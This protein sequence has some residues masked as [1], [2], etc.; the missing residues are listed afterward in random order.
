MIDEEGK[1]KHTHKR[2]MTTE[3]EDRHTNTHTETHVPTLKRHRGC[4]AAHAEPAVLLPAGV[5]R[6]GASVCA[7]RYPAVTHS[8]GC[9]GAKVGGQEE[10]GEVKGRIH[11]HD[12][13]STGRH[14]RK[15]NRIF[16]VAADVFSA[17]V[18]SAVKAGG[19]QPGKHQRRTQSGCG[20]CGYTRLWAEKTRIERETERSAPRQGRYS[21]DGKP[22]QQSQ[23]RTNTHTHTDNFTDRRLQ[24][25]EGRRGEEE[26]RRTTGREGGKRWRGGVG[27]TNTITPV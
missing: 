12:K 20:V 4:S 22:H 5:S 9:K 19:T 13:T 10:G 6:G 23:M 3:I 16:A 11:R 27:A 7:S 25:R 15:S 14:H 18:V 2:N 24:R 8:V 17:T 21:E 26:G 1:Y